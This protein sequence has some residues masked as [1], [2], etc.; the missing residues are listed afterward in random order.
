MMADSSRHWASTTGGPRDLSL[1]GFGHTG[2]RIYEEHPVNCPGREE[3]PKDVA[4]SA[5]PLRS[6]SNF[7]AVRRALR[8]LSVGVTVG[9]SEVAPIFAVF[10]DTTSQITNFEATSWNDPSLRLPRLPVRGR[11][12]F[13]PIF[14][15]SSVDV[16]S[17]VLNDS[18]CIS[19]PEDVADPDRLLKFGRAGWY[20][21]YI[22]VN[23]PRQTVPH[24]ISMLNTASSKLLATANLQSLDALFELPLA[25]ENLVKM[26]AVLAPRLA[27]TIGPYASEASELI[28]SHLAVLTRTDDERH[29]RTVYPSEPILAEASARLTHIYGW[30]SPLS[31][32]VHYVQGGIVEARFGGELI[33]KIVCLI[34]MDNALSQIPIPPD[35]WR[36]SRPIPV[37]DF[38]D[39]LII[40]LHGYSA[41]S[42]YL[43][44]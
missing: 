21:A 25:P 20:S 13:P 5:M 22:Q 28:T 15:F 35:R 1:H 43:A 36:F 44:R 8:Y 37:S 27:L 38:L 17:S 30:A 24:S 9:A 16:Y 7:R 3:H 14:I 12:R 42:V 10:T 2:D 31:A 18:N 32:L 40:P 33:T 4:E 34:A 11:R 26:L 6:F 19:S 41:F 23:I 29:L 39:H